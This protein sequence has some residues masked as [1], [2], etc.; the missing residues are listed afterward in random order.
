MLRYCG[1]QIAPGLLFSN[2][3]TTA[4]L[5]S[6]NRFTVPRVACVPAPSLMFVE[7]KRSVT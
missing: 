5:V 3:T 1:T 7:A 4:S 2:S 6:G